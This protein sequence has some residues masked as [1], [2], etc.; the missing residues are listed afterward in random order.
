[1][2]S[3]LLKER[4]FH[5]TYSFSPF[6]AVNS[7]DVCLTHPRIAFCRRGT[8][9][10]WAERGA[11]ERELMISSVIH[12]RVSYPTVTPPDAFAATL[13]LRGVLVTVQCAFPTEE[14]RYE[15]GL[16]IA[17]RWNKTNAGRSS[18]ASRTR[19]YG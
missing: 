8:A 6:S 10:Y 15:V 7:A 5:N 2:F 4:A 16:G 9:E 12:R 3:L 18:R 1:M 14:E 11:I 13:Y 17:D 19:K